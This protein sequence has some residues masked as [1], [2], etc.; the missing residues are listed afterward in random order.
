MKNKKYLVLILVVIS[1]VLVALGVT[2]ASFTFSGVGQTENKIKTGTV[3]M[4][5]T[6][7][8][9]KIA[10]TNAM[11][12]ED[13]EGKLLTNNDQ[14]FDFTV[15][16]NTT[17]AIAY[18]VTAV[19]DDNA[20]LENTDVRLYLERSL[21]GTKYEE[22][23]AP[24][25]YTP[26]KEDDKFGAKKG[27]MI[28]D[29]GTVSE[30]TSYKYRLRMWLSKDYEITSESKS[31]TVRVNVYGKEG[32]S[33]KKPVSFAT[34]DW[35]TIIGN[36]KIGNTDTY[37]VGDT[38][39]V[40]MGTLGTHTVRISNKSTPDECKI[41]GFSQTACGF[42]I[43][44][45]DIITTHNMNSDGT[46]KGG[47]PASS[48]RAYINDT[49]IPAMPKEVQKGML[50]TYTVSGHGDNPGESNFESIDKMYLLSS[51]EVWSNDT[52]YDTAYNLTR[53]LD[54]YKNN[55]VDSTNE[56]TK[57]LAIKK[58]SGTER[59]WW[60]RPATS[61]VTDSFLYVGTSGD[62][63]NDDANDTLDVSPAFRIG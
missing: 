50:D 54:Y 22:V 31:F 23:L 20:T 30:N 9:N 11:P 49:I 1:V 34:D 12:I 35:K 60:L 51:H 32:N 36:V 55:N 38:K 39:E 6:E 44:F 2:F 5:Y 37:K 57:S 43:E 16:I 61:T 4:V 63:D 14:V 53:Q 46:N 18:E 15:D 62:G 59:E 52:T 47:W 19:K 10:I 29:T 3:T 40:D 27:E 28:L 56:A 58:N 41:E 48:M 45:A 7:G 26:T 17:Q 24:S 13:S 42:V 21:D 33:I 8:E 25:N